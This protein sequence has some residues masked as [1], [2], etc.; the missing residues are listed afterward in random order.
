MRFPVLL[1]VALSGAMLVAGCAKLKNPTQDWTPERFYKEAKRAMVDEDYARAIKY[2]ET[3][4][5]RYPYG[6]YAEQAQLEIGYAYYKNGENELSLEAADRFIRL[7]PAH[8]HVAYAYYLKG[9]VNIRQQDLG[10]ARWFRLRGRDTLDRDTKAAREAYLAFR[11]VVERFP[12]SEYARDSALRMAYLHNALAKHEVDVAKFYYVQD[13]YVAAVNRCKYV[14]ENFQHTPAVED[15]L[16]I[17][18][19]AYQKMGLTDLMQDTLRVLSMNFPDS[20][21]L[22]ELASSNGKKKK[23]KKKKKKKKKDDDAILRY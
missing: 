19:M 16:G 6:R 3:M 22:Q 8:P 15:A 14:I 12:E 4:E 7:H 10:V 21:Y 11:E 13:A 1:V 23:R 2:F 17:Q 5:A 18:A 9:L 20:L